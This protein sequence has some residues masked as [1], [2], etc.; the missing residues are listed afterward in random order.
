MSFSAYAEQARLRFMA[1]AS[2]AHPRDFILAHLALDF[3]RQVRFGEDVHVLTW[4]DRVGTTSV[5]LAQRVMANDVGAAD[6]RSV[7][8]RFDY[9]A[10]RPTPFDDATRA[11]LEVRR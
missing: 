10:Q 9:A 6:V 5:T 3:R 11:W 4:V 7:V 1:E 2:D 8:V